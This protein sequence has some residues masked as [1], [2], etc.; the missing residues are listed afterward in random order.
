[1]LSTDAPRDPVTCQKFHD[2]LDTQIL[3]RE[4]ATVITAETIFSEL[5]LDLPDPLAADS[6]GFVDAS[7]AG[8]EPATFP[9]P[10]DRTVPVCLSPRDEE[11]WEEDEDEEWDEDYEDEEDLDEDEEYDEDEDEDE[12]YDDEDEEEFW[13]EDYDDEEDIEEDYEEDEE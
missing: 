11:E 9:M 3:S 13:D 5:V 10:S 1:M 4:N 8:S 6:S 7:V 2:K 12:D